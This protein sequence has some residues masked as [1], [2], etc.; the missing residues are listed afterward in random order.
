MIRRSL[1]AA[2]ARACLVALAAIPLLG[3]V[4][5]PA[6]AQAPAPYARFENAAKKKR[7]KK[8]APKPAPAPRP[9]P[10]PAPQPGPINTPSAMEAEI[11]RRV[12]EIRVRNGLNALQVN[13]GIATVARDYSRL[14]AEKGFFGHQGPNGD[15]PW[16]RVREA[17]FSFRMC[18]ENLFWNR[19]VPDPVGYAVNGWMES[20]GHRENILRTG[21]TQTGVG[22]W[23]L[24]D[25][26]Y[27]TQ[28]FYTP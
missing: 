13:P 1:S 8:P 26:Y 15:M 22:I 5:R 4:S 10:Q 25:T 12:N 6:A 9:A 28:L 18:G 17:G 21:Y 24:G 7:K 2:L 20:A 27:F 14:M 19:N 11:V 16:D 3:L 23:K